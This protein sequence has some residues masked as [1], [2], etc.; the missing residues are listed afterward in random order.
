MP[1]IVVNIR[2]EKCDVKITRRGNVPC[3]GN[4]FPV[5]VFG[6]ERCLELYDEHFHR[7]IVEDAAF[8]TAILALRDKKIG[9][10]CKPLPCHGD[11]IKKWLDEQ[12]S[13]RG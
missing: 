5:E 7:R 10:V 1:T 4:P 13:E 6:R 2:T 9:C 12:E 3:F 8:R 11:I